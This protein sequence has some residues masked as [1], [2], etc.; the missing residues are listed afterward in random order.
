MKFDREFSLDND[1]VKEK[2]EI[3]KLLIS[4]FEQKKKFNNQD[5][6]NDNKQNE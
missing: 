3:R 4:L 1:P 2:K 6:V 5:Q